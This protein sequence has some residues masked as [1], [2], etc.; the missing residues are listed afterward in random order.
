MTKDKL[1]DNILRTICCLNSDISNK[2]RQLLIKLFNS[3][4][5]YTNNT[6]LE[7][8]VKVITQK[9]NELAETV[10]ELKTKVETYSNKINELEQRVHQLEN[11]SQS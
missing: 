5:D 9:H 6:E 11:A 2:D 3:I 10:N 8:D 4:V 1:K 7:Q